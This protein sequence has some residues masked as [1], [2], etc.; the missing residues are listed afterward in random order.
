[1]R[2]S[3]KNSDEWFSEFADSFFSK[4]GKRMEKRSPSPW[5]SPPDER[6]NRPPSFGKI[7]GF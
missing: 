3:Q 1:M 7:G 2:A 4:G 6:E 5:S